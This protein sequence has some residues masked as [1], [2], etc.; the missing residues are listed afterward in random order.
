ME[1]YL[2]LSYILYSHDVDKYFTLTLLHSDSEDIFREVLQEWGMGRLPL[3]WM[4]V[5]KLLQRVD[6]W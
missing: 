2:N 3:E 1:S 6:S 5:K 4:N